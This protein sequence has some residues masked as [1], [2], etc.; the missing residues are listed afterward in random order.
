MNEWLMNKRKN[1]I[2]NDSDFIEEEFPADKD[3]L[4]FMKFVD[5][6]NAQDDAMLANVVGEPNY[7]LDGFH[8]VHEDED[9]G[10]GNNEHYSEFNEKTDMKNP[11]F[12]L[13]LIFRD[14]AQFK[15]A[16]VMHSMINGY[17]NVY[18]PRNEKFKVD[19]ACKDGC[20][21]L[22]KCWKMC[23]SNSMQIK[24]ILDHHTCA[25][26]KHGCSK[27]KAYRAITT[28]MK[29]IEDGCHLKSQHVGQLFIA[30]GIDPND[31]TWVIAYAVVEM[32]NK[33]S[34]IWFLEILAEDLGI[35]N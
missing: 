28:A 2:K 34:W 7:N 5:H 26:W 31:E 18:F 12:S 24:K 19:A 9:S 20:P 32:E 22:V 21:W 3:H 27:M 23:N 17:G 4:Q 14:V 15:K 8:S 10:P 1:K 35:I 6:V 30:V 13:G 33:G 25:K 29:I 16:V 11:H